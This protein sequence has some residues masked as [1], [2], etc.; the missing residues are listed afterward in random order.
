MKKLICA[1]LSLAMI[2]ALTAGGTAVFAEEPAQEAK[3][4]LGTRGNNLYVNEA[5]GIRIEL[6]DNWSILNDDEIAELMGISKELFNEDALAELLEKNSGIFDFYAMKE[7]SSGDNL[8]IQLQGL[9]AL[10][11]KV[12]TEELIAESS[13][14]SLKKELETTGIEVTD[15]DRRTVEFA[16]A[17]HPCLFVTM[18]LQDMPLYSCAVL[19]MSGSYLATITATSLDMSRAEE[20]LDLFEQA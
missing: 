14:K 11:S 8:N 2:L 5:F 17:E 6:P 7:D 15:I 3:D 13:E 4:M 12:L 9:S 16:G 19:I 20:I 18:K 1:L 10:Q